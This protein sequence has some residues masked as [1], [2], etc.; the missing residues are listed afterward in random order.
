MERHR[1]RASTP[2]RTDVTVTARTRASPTRSCTASLRERGHRPPTDQLPDIVY[3]EDT[4]PQVMVD[5]GQVLP[6]QSCMRRPTDY[7]IDRHRAGRCAATYIG[8]RRPL[9]RLHQ[10]VDA[11]PL[12]QPGPLRC[13]PGSTP[14][15]RPAPSRR[16]TRPAAGAE[17]RRRLRPAASLQDQP[18]VL[19]DLAD[20]RR[21]RRSSTTATAGT[22]R[23]PRPTF[24]TPRPRIDLFELL[25]Q[26]NDEGLL[27]PFADTEGSIDHYL[28]LVS[29]DS[30]M[31]DRDVDRGRPRSTTPSAALDPGRQARA[32]TTSASTASTS[33]PGRA[34]SP[35]SRS[36]GQVPDRA[37]APSTSSTPPSP[38]SRPRSWKF[39][40]YMLEPE[41]RPA[42]HIQGGYL[43][44]VEDG[45]RGPRVQAFWQDALAGR[46]AAR[47]STSADGRPRLPRPADR[48]LH[49]LRRRVEAA[50]EAVLLDGADVDDALRRARSDEVTRVARALRARSDDRGR[51]AHGRSH[52]LRA[53]VA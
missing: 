37:A 21:R 14:T 41:Q 40:E 42:W 17:G 5:S 53:R 1:R 13:G 16:S 12:L 49:R 43:P 6:A 44:V 35:A 47:P 10:R 25:K 23:P 8:R 34:P 38:R 31:L 18:L 2:A 22:A 52:G 50:M 30:S 39:L 24:D 36:P 11:G 45:G 27:N 33:S 26:M 48:A 46:A 51:P 19:R 32:S 3:L 28:A 29:Q 9:P 4:Q 7:D 20:R 15:T